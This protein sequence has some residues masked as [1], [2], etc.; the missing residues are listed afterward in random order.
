M[1]GLMPKALP[2]L[3]VTAPICCA[4][5]SATPISDDDALQ[6]ALR[7]KA[8]ADPVRVKLLS[9]LLTAPDAEMCTGDLAVPLNVAESTVSHH[10]AQLRKAGM[11]EST[12]HGMSVCHRVRR[13]SLD[14]LRAVLDPNCCA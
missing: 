10:L 2:V 6:L 5:V 13:D 1:I 3:D 9:L 8:L 14:A 7:L 11:V 12:R 4:P